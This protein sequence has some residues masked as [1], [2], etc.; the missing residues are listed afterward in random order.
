MRKWNLK[1][2]SQFQTI[3]KSIQIQLSNGIQI[4]NP[5]LLEIYVSLQ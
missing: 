2:K 4:S 5:L 1:I 3:K